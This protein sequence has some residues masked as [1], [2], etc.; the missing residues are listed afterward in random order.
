MGHPLRRR[1]R[2]RLQR[3]GGSSLEVV[4]RAQNETGKK[5]FSNAWS[6]FL[7]YFL[8]RNV[9]GNELHGLRRERVQLRPRY[10]TA[11]R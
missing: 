1:R 4:R 8:S 5:W 9:C 10:R 11:S 6:G 7:S 3:E 2:C